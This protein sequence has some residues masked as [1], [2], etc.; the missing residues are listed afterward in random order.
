ML[1]KTSPTDRVR[2]ESFR[3]IRNYLEAKVKKYRGLPVTGFRVNPGLTVWACVRHPS[4]NYSRKIYFGLIE[5]VVA[6]IQAGRYEETPA[7]DNPVE[8]SK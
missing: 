4:W 5:N 8:V 1:W 3:D 6:E 7:V 2:I